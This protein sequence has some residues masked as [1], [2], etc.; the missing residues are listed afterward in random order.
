MAH[1]D[2]ADE[3]GGDRLFAA[4]MIVVSIAIFVLVKRAER[5]E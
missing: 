1:T 3:D 2:R 4:L 5:E